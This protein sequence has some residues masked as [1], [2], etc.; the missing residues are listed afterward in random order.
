MQV[1]H[2]ETGIVVETESTS[3]NPGAYPAAEN[4]LLGFLNA[5]MSWRISPRFV[6]VGQFHEGFAVAGVQPGQFGLINLDGGFV[7][8]NDY[9]DARP[10]CEGRAAVQTA[11]GWG[12]LDTSG[13]MAISPGHAEVGA[14]CDGLAIVSAVHH[15]SA[16]AWLNEDA[17][18]YILPTGDAAFAA[19]FQQAGVFHEGYAPAR[20]HGKWGW[21][22]RQ[23]DW[24]IPNVYDAVT[25]FYHGN[26]CARMGQRQ[27]RIGTSGRVLEESADDGDLWWGPLADGLRVLRRGDLYGYAD[28]DNVVR[29]PA[30]FGTAQSFKNGRATVRSRRRWGVIDT[31]GQFV[32]PPV[33]NWLL[34]IGGLFYFVQDREN[35]YM[36]SN[37]H[38]LWSAPLGGNVVYRMQEFS[39]E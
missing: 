7:S 25:G 32:I 24:A 5:E 37:G 17:F 4:G 8:R 11:E 1:A 3:S 21:I 15:T 33:F 39:R 9:R 29:I 2:E 13:R 6:N 28:A 14:F 35:G 30:M 36:D 18:G 31:A 34:P 10:M 19:R 22:N 16:A 26:A 12:F 23:G 27:L 20:R 38:G